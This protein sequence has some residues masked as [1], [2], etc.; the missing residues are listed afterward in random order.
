MYM[1]IYMYIYICIYIHIYVYIYVYILYICKNM[2]LFPC[3]RP[4]ILTAG[5][6]P[7]LGR[8]SDPR[9]DPL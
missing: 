2:H 9:L 7:R 8:P 6:R 1:Y 4:R 5:L 3:I